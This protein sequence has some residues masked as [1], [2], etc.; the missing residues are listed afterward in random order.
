MKEKELIMKTKARWS[1][2][3]HRSSVSS[4]LKS[5]LK[6]S[7]QN[8][9]TVKLPNYTQYNNFPL[10]K[11]G[12]H[13][14]KW[15]RH[16][17]FSHTSSR[18][19][20]TQLS[21]SAQLI[22]QTRRH[23]NINPPSRH[24]NKVLK[25]HQTHS[26]PSSTLVWQC[27]VSTFYT[28]TPEDIHLGRIVRKTCCCRLAHVRFTSKLVWAQTTAATANISTL[29]FKTPNKKP[30]AEIFRKI[31]YLPVCLFTPVIAVKRRIGDSFKH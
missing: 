7:I 28:P 14:T 2:I 13:K 10:I 9:W 15:K 20:I 24:K 16:K 29:T 18:L 3:C 11:K 6:R 21:A 30:S 27:R 19:I 26:D 17:L 23:T 12:H 1:D 25:Q 4:T 5:T 31:L 8:W 22:P